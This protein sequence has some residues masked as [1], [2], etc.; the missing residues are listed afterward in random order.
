MIAFNPAAMHLYRQRLRL[1][2]RNIASKTGMT[3]DMAWRIENGHR[4]PTVEQLTA[5]AA[6][7]EITEDSLLQRSDVSESQAR[8][9]RV[10]PADA[11][12]PRTRAGFSPVSHGAS[13]TT[14][15]NLGALPPVGSVYP[16]WIEQT[17]AGPRLIRI[18]S[19]DDIDRFSIFPAD[20]ED[21]TSTSADRY[22]RQRQS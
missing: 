13:A 16:A 18:F 21:D 12:L 5:L 20:E 7:L 4:V 9:G 6:A 8:Q 11:V 17:E 10:V 3:L 1:S 2:L 22:T 15:G 19:R 14:S